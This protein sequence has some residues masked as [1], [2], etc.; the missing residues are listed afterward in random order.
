MAATAVLAAASLE[1][2]RKHRI[3][4]RFDHASAAYQSI[5]DAEPEN[6]AAWEGLVRSLLGGKKTAEAL[7]A[8]DKVYA[9]APETAEAL[10]AWGLA[11]IRRGNLGDAE[12]AF[13]K[14]LKLKTNY[15]GAIQGL[16]RI[17]GTLSRFKTAAQ[18]SGM[19][20]RLQPDEPSYWIAMSND[21]PFGAEHIAALE[22][23][24]AVMDPDSEAARSLRVHIASDKAIGDRKLY[25][26][27]SPYQ[28][29]EVKLERLASPD[30]R[31][32]VKVRLN[33]KTTST[34]LLDT[35][36]SGI[37][38][39]KGL[40]KDAKLEILTDLTAE[41]GGIGDGKKRSSLRA[42]AERVSIG[43]VTLRNIPVDVVEKGDVGGR[44]GIIGTDV[45]EQF[46]ITLDM[47][48]HRMQLE[49]YP[50][51]TAAPD[52]SVLH[53]GDAKLA[54]GFHRVFRAGHHLLIPTSINKGPNRMF[55]ID[56]GAG[57]NMADPDVIRESTK[58]RSDTRSQVRGMQ[59]TVK[60]V[61]RADRMLMMFGNIVQ[62]NTGAYAFDLDKTSD[63][64]GIEIAGLIGMPALAQLR[65]TIDYRNG[66]VKF[67]YEKQ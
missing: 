61:Y 10:T 59:G 41:H 58:V 54:E 64:S 5:V 25:T 62:D 17:Y 40:A 66:A 35:G 38:V 55:L 53:D 11:S 13:R 48:R 24:L 21:N 60:N 9:L 37:V 44:D 52:L 34:M 7:A 30:I 46:L 33:D 50:S 56:T 20:S 43:G 2:A 22:K 47:P 6:A 49:P 12:T 42:L 36:A 45:L 19:A 67:E 18:L 8:A 3:A 27:E 32:G 65:I 23:A 16:A 51:L 28:S 31:V 4:G 14:A 63:S 15:P 57:M 29:H 26:L 1:D 39:T